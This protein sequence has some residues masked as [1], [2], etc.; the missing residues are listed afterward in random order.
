MNNRKHITIDCRM[1]GKDFGGIGRYVQEIV[2]N[3]IRKNKFDFTILANDEAYKDLC[4]KT[5]ENLKVI[6]CSSKMFSLSEQ[7]ELYNKIPR[8][9]VLWSPYMNVPF[10]PVNAKK[11]IVT[12]HDVFHVANPEY[13]SVLKRKL[14][15]LYYFFS[16]R[17]SAKIITVSY[18]SKKEIGKEFGR[19]IENK[20]EVVYNGCDIMSD[21]VCPKN[22]GSDY[23]LFVGSV[24]P[25]KN[26]KKALLAFDMLS[27]KGLKFVIVGKR[28]GFITGDN[29][30]SG[31]VEKINKN[32]HKVIFTDSITDADLYSYYK[33]ARMLLMPSFYEGFGLPVIEAMK[34]SI[35]IACSDIE[36]F[37]EIGGDQLF[38]FDPNSEDDIRLGIEKALQN[39]NIIYSKNISSWE[40]VSEN[41]SNILLK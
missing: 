26:L 40:T 15:S 25:H 36:V 14:I 27:N 10:L 16:T 12:I 2:Q 34:F 1:Y 3:L 20:T 38:Y 18:F 30:I 23:I 8:C 4:Q 37:H 31:I 29:S 11:R 6:S 21:T 9:D 41:I 35:P 24:K 32:D 7:L 39:D 13:Y 22:I 33:G 19:D 17:L 28:E 5:N